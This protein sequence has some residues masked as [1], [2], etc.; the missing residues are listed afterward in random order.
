MLPR[1][2]PAVFS[3]GWII[4]VLSVAE[5]LMAAVALAGHDGEAGSFAVAAAISGMFGGAAVLGSEGRRVELTFRD[6]VVLTVSAWFILPV[7]AALPFILAPVD[8]SPVDAYFEM[9]S[10]VT[11]TGSTVMAGLDHQAPSIL[12]WRSTVQWLGGFGIIG[13]AIVIL[14]FLR[15]GGMQLLRLE[16]SD[17]SE[18]VVPRAR[19]VAVTV[20]QIYVGLTFLCFLTYAALGMSPFDALNHAFA[21]LCTGGFSTHD[22]SFGAFGPAIRWAGVVF[23]AAG[24][25]PFLAYFRLAGGR[26]LGRKLDTQVVA[27]LGVLAFFAVGLAMYLIT[28][29][30]EPIGASFTDATFNV[31]SVI[32][33]T[34]FASADYS[35]WGDLPTFAFLIM[36]LVGGCTGST[37]GGIK[38]MR[39]QIME[40]TFV[41]QIRRLLYPHIAQPVRFAGQAVTSEEV[42]SVGV[43]IVVYLSLVAAAAG[44]LV[45]SGM[46][47]ISAISAAAEAAGNVGPGLGPIVGPAGNF[48][49]LTSFQKLVMSALMVLGRLEIL[50]VLVLFAP[51]FYR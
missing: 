18:K 40:A 20:G 37:A 11:T 34:G 7:F 50:S 9:I 26:A 43:F 45:A 49:S 14:P 15:I 2:R 3:L 35:Q 10:A 16:L 17:R 12:L 1:L 13:L 33:T 4:V 42:I 30:Q 38:I 23:M 39:L 31:V 28:T 29:K 25:I 5:A 32:T 48:A 46:D 47:N 27:F 19:K 8:L 41:Q 21:T 24:A 51:R 6:A 44:L 36:T 22:A